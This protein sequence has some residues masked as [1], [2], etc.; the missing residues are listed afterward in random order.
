MEEP[1]EMSEKNNMITNP[2][3]PKSNQHVLNPEI[4]QN[5]FSPHSNTAILF[6]KI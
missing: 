2:L 6:I 4:D 5:L 3:N 1:V